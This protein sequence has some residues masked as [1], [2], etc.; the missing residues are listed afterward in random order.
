MLTLVFKM[1][2]SY[3]P[4]AESVVILLTPQF[5]TECC[6]MLSVVMLLCISD[7]WMT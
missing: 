3:K 1:G 5:N 4:I 2:K 6:L 7:Y